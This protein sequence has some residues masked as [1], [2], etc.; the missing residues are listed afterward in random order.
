MGRR[1]SPLQYTPQGVDLFTTTL[2]WKAAEYYVQQENPNL[3]PGPDEQSKDAYYKAVAEV[4]NRTIERT[5]PNYTTMQR[6]RV[7]RSKSELAKTLNMYKTQQYQNYNILYDAQGDWRAQ[8]RRVQQAQDVIDELSREAD[9]PERQT[10]LQ[11][12]RTALKTAQ[13]RETEARKRLGLALTSQFLQSAGV[14]AINILAM[15]PGVSWLL[16]RPEK[17]EKFEDEEGEFSA[18][19]L[20]NTMGKELVGSWFGM[21]PFASPLWDIIKS[22]PIEGL[23]E[24]YYGVDADSL[25][26]VTDTVNSLISFLSY[27]R[28]IPAET[29]DRHFWRTFRLE[30][31]RVIAQ[32]AK[33]KGIPAA[34]ILNLFAGPVQQIVKAFGGGAYGEYLAATLTSK[35]LASDGY[36][37]LWEALRKEDFDSYRKIAA[38]LVNNVR[39]S[40]GESITAADLQNKM[41]TKYK[42]ASEQGKAVPSRKALDFIGQMK[43]WEPAEESEDKFSEKDLNAET[44]FRWNNDRL[45]FYSEIRDEI[46]RYGIA[47]KVESDVWGTILDTADKLTHEVTLTRHSGGKYSTEDLD[48]WIQWAAFAPEVGVSEAQAVLFYAAHKV[49]EADY[50]EDSDGN[51]KT[52]KNSYR[53]KTVELAREWMPDLTYQQLDYLKSNFW[54]K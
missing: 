45:S 11:E 51:Q 20:M 33:V 2:L 28:T 53:D 25:G 30:V 43:D 37:L 54:S 46:D 49:T 41:R 10:A 1:F 17:P 40:S 24:R 13:E 36:N 48:K 27:V 50:E 12:A 23:G 29:K 39:N 26:L 14:M 3:K 22:L 31:T 38:D 42:K 34:N 35:N 44:F 7:L 19:K 8:I 32:A 4:Y 9:T 18:L 47:S 6:A 5:Q 16:G 52:V 21:V 15:V